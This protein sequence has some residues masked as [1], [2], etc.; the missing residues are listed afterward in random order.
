M[1]GLSLPIHITSE[2]DNGK[3]MEDGEGIELLCHCK[4]K[5]GLGDSEEILTKAINKYSDVIS[6]AENEP[7]RLWKASFCHV[8]NGN[9]GLGKPPKKLNSTKEALSLVYNE[10]GQLKYLGVCFDGAIQDYSR[11]IELCPNAITFYNRGQVYFR[12]GMQ[13]SLN[14]AT[15]LQSL[16]TA[17]LR[18]F[19]ANDST[20]SELGVVRY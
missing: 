19:V 14:C 1:H 13:P 6:E 16:G 9:S 5:I 15:T 11:A 17:H 7:D 8:C 20:H 4:I 10:R 2:R 12:L 18:F 3:S